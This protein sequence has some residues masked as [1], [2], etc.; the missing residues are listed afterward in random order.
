M[1]AEDRLEPEVG[2]VIAAATARRLQ[3][4]RSGEGMSTGRERERAGDVWR[5]P[6]AL[7]WVRDTRIELRA[8]GGAVRAA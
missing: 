8:I 2:W 5:Q 7:V 6:P 3:R 4:R 1:F